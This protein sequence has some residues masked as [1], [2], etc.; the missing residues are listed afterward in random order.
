MTE[1]TQW[2]DVAEYS[3]AATET[4]DELVFII[5]SG[6]AKEAIVVVNGMEIDP[7]QSIGISYHVHTNP[8]SASAEIIEEELDKIFNMLLTR[9]V[10]EDFEKTTGQMSLD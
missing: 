7:E 8:N 2:A 5:E 9:I 3:L 1:S 6:P 10:S 4:P